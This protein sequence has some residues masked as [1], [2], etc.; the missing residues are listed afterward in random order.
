MAKY[1]IDAKGAENLENLAVDLKKLQDNIAEESKRLVRVVEGYGTDLGVY[2][3]E[4]LELVRQVRNE[5]EKSEDAVLELI[6]KIHRN[7]ETIRRMIPR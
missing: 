3:D 2:E 6:C 4:I 5:Q 7:A 1:G